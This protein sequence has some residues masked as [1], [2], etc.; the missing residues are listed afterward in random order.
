M[1]HEPLIGFLSDTFRGLQQR[2][3][4]VDKSRFAIMS[5]FRRLEY[6]ISGGLRI[7]TYHRN[8]AYIF[9]SK[10]CVSLVQKTAAQ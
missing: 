2:W 4:T 10:A 3:A 1:T 7:F 8:L 9:D 5:S 6:L